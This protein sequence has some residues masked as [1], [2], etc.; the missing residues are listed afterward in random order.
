MAEPR[1]EGEGQGVAAPPADSR[2]RLG[3]ET[4]LLAWVRTGLALM[5]FGFVL[6]R[7][8]LFLLELDQAG[9]ASERQIRISFA[10]GTMLIALGVF[11][12]LAAAGMHYP[13]LIRTRRGETDLPAPGGS[14]SSCPWCWRRWAWAWRCSCSS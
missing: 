13:Y 5:G 3:L 9:H 8:G 12:N 1:P 11:I 4:T 7:F 10:S 14:A 6:A 2:L